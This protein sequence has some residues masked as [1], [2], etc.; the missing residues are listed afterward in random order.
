M[1]KLAVAILHRTVSASPGFDSR[2][3]HFALVE[4]VCWEL[5]VLFWSKFASV[6]QCGSRVHGH[7]FLSE[8]IPLPP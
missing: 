5:L 6:A 4:D 3:M 1:V 8:R 2:P 7:C